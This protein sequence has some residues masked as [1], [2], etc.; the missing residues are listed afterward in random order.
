MLALGLQELPWEGSLQVLSQR[1][2]RAALKGSL[3]LWPQR[4]GPALDAWAQPHRLVSALPVAPGVSRVQRGLSGRL[5]E[6]V[7]ERS[8]PTGGGG[9]SVIFPA[10]ISMWEGPKGERLCPL[11]KRKACLGMETV[12]GEGHGGQG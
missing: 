9:G 6:L 5:G 2:Y 4:E 1:V 7:C 12:G 3:P 10:Q 8:L 11:L